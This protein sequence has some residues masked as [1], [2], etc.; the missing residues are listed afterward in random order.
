M[1]VAMRTAG[2]VGRLKDVLMAI[3]IESRIELEIKPAE[4]TQTKAAGLT[5][6]P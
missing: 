5:L 6:L 3:A 2:D 1:V 4:R